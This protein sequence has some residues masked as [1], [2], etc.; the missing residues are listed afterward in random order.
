MKKPLLRIGA[1]SLVFALAVVTVP[2][3]AQFVVYDPISYGELVLQYT[4]EL[5]Q[6]VK[7]VEQYLLLVKQARRVPVDIETRYHAYSLDWTFHNLDSSLLY[8]RALLQALNA[9]DATGAAYQGVVT[10]L[11]VP[12]DVVGRMPADMQRRLGDAYATI[13]AGDSMTRLAVDQAGQARAEGPLTLQAI[14]NVEHDIDNPGD[15]FHSQTA[16]LEKINAAFAIGLR[17]EEQTNQFQLSALEQGMLDNKRKRDAEAT[18]M[19][20]TI[21][22]W[23]YGKAYGD[24]LFRNTAANI[25]NWRPY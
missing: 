9:G 20:A 2:L 14:R 8:A 4:Q 23:R 18:L 3:K 19:N 5:L 17:L 25:D 6:Y 22:Q 16:L 15:D 11:D 21:R 1:I 12:T 10:P 7:Q 13:E 24:D